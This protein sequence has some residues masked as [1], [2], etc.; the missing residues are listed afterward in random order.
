MM[1][2]TNTTIRATTI[3]QVFVLPLFFRYSFV[4]FTRPSALSLFGCRVKDYGGVIDV[5]E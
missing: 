1:R 5:N 3:D 4:F 2:I